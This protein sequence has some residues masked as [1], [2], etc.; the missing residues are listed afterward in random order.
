M[1]QARQDVLRRRLVDQLRSGSD[2]MVEATWFAPVAPYHDPEHLALERRSLLRRHPVVVAHADRVAEP[3][4]FVT[5]DH[6]GSPLLVARGDDGVV[7]AFHNVC[8]HRGARVELA[9]SGNRRRFSCPYHAWSYDTRG[10]L[11][12]I[13][14]DDGFCDLD[15]S[16]LALVPLAA[17]E[18]HGLIW[19]QFDADATEPLDVAGFLGELDDELASYRLDSYVTERREVLTQPFNWKLLVDGFLEVYHLRFLHRNTVGPYIRSNF[20]LV[21]PVGPHTRMVGIRSSFDAVVERND[22]PLMRHLAIIYQVFPNTVLVWQGDHFESWT[23]WP[24]ES[25]P[26][27]TAT[28]VALLA[29]HPTRDEDEQL[30]WDKNWKILMDTVLAEDFPTARGIQQGYGAGAQTHV[31]FGRQEG[32]LQHY[33]QQLAL[34]TSG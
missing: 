16:N 15:R 6:A 19:V 5:V 11:R 33:H 24:G 32:A 22:E 14:N 9:P 23:A 31:V 29:P 20:A 34:R 1:D 30:H 7:R 26:A 2:P 18:R 28:E 3:G 27:S 13:P 4:D 17:A 10:A 21:D 12:A 25:G 8:R